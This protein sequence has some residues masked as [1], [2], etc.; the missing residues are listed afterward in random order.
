[1]AQTK[2]FL[3]K[4]PELKLNY[5]AGRKLVPWENPLM[6]R[7][8]RQ[9]PRRLAQFKVCNQTDS[10]REASSK[11][12]W[13]WFVEE[14]V[15][16]ASFEEKKAGVGVWQETVLWPCCSGLQ[17]RGLLAWINPIYG[18]KPGSERSAADL[19]LVEMWDQTFRI[20]KA[21]KQVYTT[22]VVLLIIP[23]A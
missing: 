1:M 18:V 19:D 7:E 3:G 11:K 8:N 15:K 4:R 23:S 13:S 12:K 22:P 16:S 10:S 14:F 2:S 20:M 5:T 21:L 17:R 9:T 6:Y